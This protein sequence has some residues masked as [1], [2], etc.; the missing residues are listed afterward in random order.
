MRLLFLTGKTAEPMEVPRPALHSIPRHLRPCPVLRGAGA[1]AQRDAGRRETRGAGAL[2]RWRPSALPGPPVTCQAL[3]SGPSSFPWCGCSFHHATASEREEGARRLLSDPVGA[4]TPSHRRT[5]TGE[6][7]WLSAWKRPR[8]QET[9]RCFAQQGFPW[10]RLKAEE[11]LTLTISRCAYLAACCWDI[12]EGTQDQRYQ[13]G[14]KY[15]LCM[16]DQGGLGS[17]MQQAAWTVDRPYRFPFPPAC[18]FSFCLVA[19]AMLLHAATWTV[20]VNMQQGWVQALNTL[21]P[22]LLGLLCTWLSKELSL[23]VLG[24]FYRRKFGASL[25]NASSAPRQGF[26][27]TVNKFQWWHVNIYKPFLISK[28]T[29][30]FPK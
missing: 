14:C 4:R 13:M 19:L 27:P 8:A 16:F 15:L 28:R 1:R 20:M 24:C 23:G 21:P 9:E 17:V 25:E 26:L 11:C 22:A 5:S 3:G 18:G 6:L 29:W 12:T 30:I 10:F 7:C 2:R